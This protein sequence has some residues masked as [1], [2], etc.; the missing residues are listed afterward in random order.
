LYGQTGTET[1]GTE[2]GPERSDLNVQFWQ[3]DNHCGGNHGNARA[4]TEETTQG[5][6][7]LALLTLFPSQIGMTATEEYA[8]D[9]YDQRPENLET[10][11][12]QIGHY[13]VINGANLFQL[14]HRRGS[15]VKDFS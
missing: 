10:I 7:R 12:D 11:S 2:S 8:D 4:A 14:F 9:Q 3:G 5:D 6:V 1:D 13:H 15:L